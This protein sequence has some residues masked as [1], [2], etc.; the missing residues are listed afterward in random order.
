MDYKRIYDNIIENARCR[1]LADALYV[2]AHHV[3]PKCIGGLDD[4]RNIVLLTPEEHFLCHLLLVKIFPNEHK[5]IFALS[6]MCLPISGRPK[7]KLYGW[8]RRRHADAMSSV[9]KQ[10]SGSKNSQFGTRW[11]NNGIISKKIGGEQILP[12]GF[13]Y[14]RVKKPRK[15]RSKHNKSD[16]NKIWASNF[17]DNVGRKVT[18]D[19]I[20]EALKV[21]NFNISMAMKKCGY[22]TIGGYSRRRFEKLKSIYK[23]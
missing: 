5:L 22:V 13:T 1:L 7:R 2:E 8:L 12:I 18:D 15:T 9:M 20:L 6:M 14:G 11:I 3:V 17:K 10:Y 21:N 19:E 4:E 16:R 23:G